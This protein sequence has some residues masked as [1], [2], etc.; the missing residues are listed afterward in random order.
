MSAFLYLQH[1][2]V[3]Y[4]HFFIYMSMPISSRVSVVRPASNRFSCVCGSPRLLRAWPAH[5]S[6][7]VGKRLHLLSTTTFLI[8]GGSFQVQLR[9]RAR[10]ESPLARFLG[11]CPQQLGPPPHPQ[12]T[13]KLVDIPYAQ[14]VKSSAAKW[15]RY[16]AGKRLPPFLW[17]PVTVTDGDARRWRT[18]T[19]PQHR[20][21]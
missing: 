15:M 3:I 11:R 4:L 12:T 18:W 16:L 20:L 9:S 21:Q 6:I 14:T 5:T 1:L 17:Q 13:T 2:Q 7:P 10:T 19:E 8:A